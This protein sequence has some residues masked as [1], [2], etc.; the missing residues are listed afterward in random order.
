MFPPIVVQDVSFAYH[1]TPTLHNVTFT[2]QSGEFVGIIGP[3]GGGKT[4]LLK[5]I[6]GFLKPYSG[7]I[8]V[9]DQSP[10]EARGLLAYVPQNLGFDK[11]FPISVLELVLSGRL[12]KLSW[13]GTYSANDKKAACT[14][15]EMVG[16][17][18]Y[19][20]RP[21]GTLS[22]G[23]AQRVL[24]ARALASQ[25]KLLLLDEPTASVDTQSEADI[26]DILKDLKGEM[27]VLM[28]THEIGA[29]IKDVQRVICVQGE[30]VDLKPEEVCAHFAF[31]VYHTPLVQMVKK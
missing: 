23:Q 16:L 31:G 14:A 2:I 7:S 21:F 18:D 25:P 30:A 10:Q 26:H 22:S 15:L 27:T 5:L 6:L 12:A 13:Y 24:I 29:I 8:K 9:F 3:N 20:S 28:V 4:T 1:G 11:Q 17:L 19:Q